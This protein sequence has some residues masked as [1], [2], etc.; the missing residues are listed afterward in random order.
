[1]VEQNQREKATVAT[2]AAAASTAKQDLSVAQN[3]H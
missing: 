3:D 2:Q 1:M